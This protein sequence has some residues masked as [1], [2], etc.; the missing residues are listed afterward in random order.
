ME[1]NI[2][3]DIILRMSEYIQLDKIN[4]LNVI[5]NNKFTRYV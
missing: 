2:N 4:K 5:T 3:V 1:I